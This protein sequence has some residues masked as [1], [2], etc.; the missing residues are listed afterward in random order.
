MY[1]LM[2]AAAIRLRFTKPDLERPYKVPG[3]EGGMIIIASLGFLGV[4]FAFIV[5]FFPPSN[6]PIGSPSTY[7]GIVVAGT[8]IFPGIACV[9]DMMQKPSWKQTDS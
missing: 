9:L 5:S 8:V 6:L 7:V 2:Y 1:M 3:G 4:L